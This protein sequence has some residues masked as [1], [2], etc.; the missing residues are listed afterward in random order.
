M[1]HLHLH[2]PIQRY[3]PSLSVAS[4]SR[5]R[6]FF[7]GFCDFMNLVNSLGVWIGINLLCFWL[8]YLVNFLRSIWFVYL[9]ISYFFFGVWIGSV[10][11][12]RVQFSK[13]PNNLYILN[14]YKHSSLTLFFSLPIILFG[15]WE[16]FASYMVL[17]SVGI[18][19]VL[20]YCYCVFVWVLRKWTG[21]SG[22]IRQELWGIVVVAVCLFGH[23]LHKSSEQVTKYWEI[24]RSWT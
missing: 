7:F 17:I 24:N 2:L 6:F 4:H 19:F 23:C 12:A 10:W 13:E 15:S 18:G 20:S 11:R 16:S 8:I 14:S 9:F 5:F 1:F 21:N 22:I 3:P